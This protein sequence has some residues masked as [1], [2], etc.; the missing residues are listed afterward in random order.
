M[1][2]MVPIDIIENEI[3]PKLDFSDVLNL[4]SIYPEWLFP[5]VLPQAN[6]MMSGL[7]VEPTTRLIK[8]KYYIL[9]KYI[10]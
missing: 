9:F 3:F 7:I 6:E 2:N 10:I 4:A 8:C 1:M 5:E